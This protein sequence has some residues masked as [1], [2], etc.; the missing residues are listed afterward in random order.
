MNQN[1]HKH[2]QISKW[3]IESNDLIFSIK[4]QKRKKV[5]KNNYM[6]I[7]K[8]KNN[9][10]KYMLLIHTNKHFFFFKIEPIL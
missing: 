5:I 2:W 7:T 8:D 10:I 4:T 1:N 6:T 9:K 3:F